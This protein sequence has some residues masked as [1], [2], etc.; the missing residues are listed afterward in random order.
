MKAYYEKKVYNSS[1]NIYISKFKLNNI[2]PHFHA[3][4][5]FLYVLKGSVEAHINSKKYIVNSDQLLVVQ[6]NH[7]H[8]YYT[9][10]MDCEVVLI[11]FDSKNVLNVDI[12]PASDYEFEPAC[13]SIDDLGLR[14]YLE[15]LVFEYDSDNA[16]K[17]F[18]VKSYLLKICGMLYRSG[19][20][21]S[22]KPKVT[23]SDEQIYNIFKYVI[24]NY[25]NP[26]LTLQTLSKY[27]NYSVSYTSKLFKTLFGVNFNSYVAN[28]RILYAYNLL[29]STDKPIIE[30]CFSSG[31][32][33][34][35]TFNKKFF[36]K[37]KTTPR[38]IRK[39][40]YH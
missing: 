17:E 18:F 27:L 14:K 19:N 3:D 20:L 34:I 7:V 8:S 28:M 2:L 10:C 30:I 25:R 33:T 1:S 31:F 32:H 29:V 16:V 6:N 13:F 22:I 40:H 26:D 9:G 5:E 12:F 39:R 35:Q 21:I 36:E 4:I 23:S 24:E 37:Y 38:N 11:I 15:E